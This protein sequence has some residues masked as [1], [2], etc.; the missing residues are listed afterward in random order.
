MSNKILSLLDDTQIEYLKTFFPNNN[1]VKV[2]SLEQI[3]YEALEGF[4]LFLVDHKLKMMQ[5]IVGVDKFINSYNGH[6]SYG[7]QLVTVDAN[8]EC[9][10]IQYVP[11]RRFSMSEFIAARPWLQNEGFE[12]KFI[13]LTSPLPIEVTKTNMYSATI[14]TFAEDISM[15]GMRIVGDF[16]PNDTLRIKSPLIPTAVFEATV[17]WNTPWGQL[18]QVPHAGI[19]IEHNPTSLSF[20]SLAQFMREQ[21][22][23]TLLKSGQLASF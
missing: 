21:F 7:V 10:F 18:G 20:K 3:Y 14:K 2:S 4:F 23:P 17:K 12:R 8:K 5:K 1:F 13:R 11:I 19:E 15:K 22:I 9:S 6:R 16:A